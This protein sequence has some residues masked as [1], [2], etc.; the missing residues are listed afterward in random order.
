ML[1]DE[2]LETLGRLYT[3]S[4]LKEHGITFEAYLECPESWHIFLG[5]NAPFEALKAA[6]QVYATQHPPEYIITLRSLRAKLNAVKLQRL[7]ACQKAIRASGDEAREILAQLLA[8]GHLEAAALVK[9]RIRYWEQ[10]RQGVT[11]ESGEGTPPAPP[12]VPA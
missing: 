1:T 11:D 5:M 8:A 2:K 4:G 7:R 3:A 9:H 12:E 6:R 10:Q